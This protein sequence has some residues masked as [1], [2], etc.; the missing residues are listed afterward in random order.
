LGRGLSF[1]LFEHRYG[2]H[3]SE[4]CHAYAGDREEQPQPES[5]ERR[6]ALH[7][8][9]HLPYH[10]TTRRVRNVIGS[11]LHLSHD[12]LPLKQRERDADYQ[13]Y[14]RAHDANESA[15]RRTL[16]AGNGQYR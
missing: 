2:E 15:R 4:R 1:A 9:G 7:R 10:F 14:E 16:T 3:S 12:A 5:N 6:M 11:L 13:I 8:V